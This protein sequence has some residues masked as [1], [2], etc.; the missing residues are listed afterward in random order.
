MYT[1]KRKNDF[2]QSEIGIE[3][4]EL[5]RQMESDASYHTEPSYSANSELYPD[6]SRSFIDTHVDYLCSHNEVAPRMYLSNLRLTTRV[7]G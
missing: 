6:N 7:R 1:I 4:C 3:A 5:L 2:M